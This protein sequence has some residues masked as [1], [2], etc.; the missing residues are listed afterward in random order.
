MLPPG[1]AAAGYLVA[2]GIGVV[3]PSAGSDMASLL[4]FGALCGA[5]PDVDMF[6]AFA[7]TRSLVIENAKQSHRAYITHTPL[8]WFALAVV[9]FAAT[10]D[11]AIA[12]LVF[13]CP[14]SHLLLDSIEDDIMWRWPFSSQP[15]RIF[16][17]THDLDIPRQDFFSYWRKFLCWY[18]TNRR[19]TAMLEAALVLLCIFLLSL[20][21][22]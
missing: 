20:E 7:K 22:G 11:V 15:Y 2:M 3:F 1:H 9:V 21:G 6:A 8:F 5:L 19:L 17:S 18:I 16:T 13:L 14:V 12:L 10:R 4:V